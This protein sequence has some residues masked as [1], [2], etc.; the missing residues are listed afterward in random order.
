MISKH[1]IDRQKF[2]NESENTCWEK[3]TL[4]AWLNND[5]YS[6]AFSNQEKSKILTASI[7]N[8]KNSQYGT[9]SGSNTYDKVFL[10]SAD[11]ANKY[12]DSSAKTRCQVTLYAKNRGVYCDA[13]YFGYWWLRTTGEKSENATYIFYTGGVSTMGYAANGTIFGVRPAMWIEI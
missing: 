5:F 1:I 2:N 7:Q 12:F 3:C 11:E 9:S 4:R 8:T 10:L 6:T 13:A